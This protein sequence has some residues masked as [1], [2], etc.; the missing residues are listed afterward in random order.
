MV[1]FRIRPFVAM[2]RKTTVLSI[3]AGIVLLILF[4]LIAGGIWQVLR[5]TPDKAPAGV[6]KTLAIWALYDGR[7]IYEPK[8]Q[9]FL[10]AHPEYRVEYRRYT[11]PEEYRAMLVDHIAEGR[12]PDVAALP[13]EWTYKD[14]FKFSPYDGT[15]VEAFRQAFVGSAADDLILPDADGKERIY[16]LPAFTDNLALYYNKRYFRDYVLGSNQP[17]PAW[18]A[19]GQDDLLRQ[20]AKL[21]EP[22][23]S[24]ER[25]LVAGIALGRTDN[26]ARGVDIFRLFLLQHG[27]QLT[28]EAAKTATLVTQRPAGSVGLPP[29]VEALKFFTSFAVSDFQ[30]YSWNDLITKREYEEYELGAFATGKLAMMYGYASDYERILTSIRGKKSRGRAAMEADDIGIL[31]VPQLQAGTAGRTT[32]ARYA[33]FMVPTTSRSK[34]EAWGFIRSLSDPEYQQAVFEKHHRVTSLIS[35]LEKQTVDP[36]YGTFALQ[37]SYARSPRLVEPGKMARIFST[38]IMDVSGDGQDPN[39]SAIAAAAKLQ[40]VLDQRNQTAGREDQD[41]LGA[42]EDQDD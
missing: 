3:V 28:D 34:A 37:A 17:A 9:E 13:N 29:F 25:F 42:D 21:T 19:T 5:G 6:Q 2:T 35:L 26:I 32:L 40:C 24:L 14:R 8:I 4:P 10:K 15:T 20:V 36:V 33:P 31:P 11:D 16:G 23:L 1:P 18:Q 27:V 41:C 22:D 39:A 12:G 7:E 38:A 30:Q